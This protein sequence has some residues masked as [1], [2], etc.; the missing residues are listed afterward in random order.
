MTR[1]RSLNWAWYVVLRPQMGHTPDEIAENVYACGIERSWEL[2]V[3]R[4]RDI[5]NDVALEGDY[6]YLVEAVVT[7]STPPIKLRAIG[8]DE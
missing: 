4:A 5:Y 1:D 2:A 6:I 7:T 8:R 3:N